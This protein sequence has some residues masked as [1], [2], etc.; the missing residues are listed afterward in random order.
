MHVTRRN[1]TPDRVPWP[2]AA[3]AVTGIAVFVALPVAGLLWRVPWTDFFG[4][5]GRA[6]SLDALRVSMIASLS[7]TALSVLFGTP[8]AWQL[9]RISTRSR[10][11]IRAAIVLP[12]VLPPVVGGIGL[13]YAF[14]RRGLVG[15]YLDD[16]FGIQIPYTIWATIIA[17]TFVAIPFYVVT[18]E[19]ALRGIDRRYVHAAASFGARPFTIMRRVVLPMIAPSVL[20]GAAL[21][22]ARA[23]G[24]FG[25]TITFAGNFQ[26]RTQTLPLAIYLAFESDDAAGLVLGVALMAVA[27]LVLALVGSDVLTARA[28]E[29]ETAQ[30]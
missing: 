8:I 20:A 14:G 29:R 13:F 16:W 26:G 15:Q 10:G 25:A 23:L 19:G 24:E 2:T 22:W 11:V 6:A 30:A 27:F 21:S 9:S 5:F 18:V 28:R 1:S 7:A 3:I 12:L 4:I 17:E